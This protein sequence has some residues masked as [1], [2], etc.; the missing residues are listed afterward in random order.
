MGMWT[1]WRGERSGWSRRTKIVAWAVA[2]VMVVAWAIAVGYAQERADAAV[3]S[4]AAASAAPERRCV[5]PGGGDQSCAQWSKKQVRKFRNGR[6]GDSAG[7][8]KEFMS[9]KKW[10]RLM[11][12]AIK[13]YEK[14]HPG[15]FSGAQRD[16]GDW[17]DVCDYFFQAERCMSTGL[18]PAGCAEAKEDSE[19]IH[20]IGQEVS[21]FAIKCGG[22]AVIGGGATRNP[23]GAIFGGVLACGWGQAADLAR[24][25]HQPRGTVA[26]REPVC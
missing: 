25:C 3:A 17:C 14:R 2:G 16:F 22:G 24:G 19:E 6:T 9:K 21:W 4:T 23:L 7:A 8:H 1:E 11:R 12:G 10:N 18:H 13:R 5:P 20:R 26:G 15:R